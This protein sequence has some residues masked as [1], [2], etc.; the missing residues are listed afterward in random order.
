MAGIKS[1][2]KDTAIYG[3]SSMVGKFLNW[4]L[5]PFYTYTLK[6]SGEYGIVT[7]LYGW[8]ALVI[9]ILTYGMETGFF[10]FAN[11]DDRNPEQVYSTTLCSLAVTSLLFI[12]LGLVFLPDISQWMGYAEHPEF[13][14]MMICIVAVDAFCCIP[15]AYLRYKNKAKT[16]AGIK[17]LMIFVNILFNLFFLWLCPK[18]HATNPEAI[19]WFFKPD[20][21]VG[22][23]FLSN[24]FSTGITFLLL[25]PYFIHVKVDFNREL[26]G[27]M[28]R[29]SMPLLVLGIAGI[30]NQT[31]DKVIFKH[32]F[33]DQATAQEQLGIYGACYKIAII[34]M[35]F[36]QAFR[37]AYEPFIFA[38]NKSE[39]NRK[40]YSEAM[41][42]Y[43]IFALFIFL[44]VMFYIDIIKYIISSNYHSGLSVVPI[45]LACYLFQGIY[46]NLSLWYK[47]TDRTQW[48]AYI[49]LF[50]CLLTVLGN[51]MFVPEYG[52]IAAAWTSFVC[53]FLMMI[54]CWALGQKFYPIRYEM[55]SALFYLVL[56][57]VL[58]ALGMNLPFDSLWLTLGVRTVLLGVFGI[59]VLKKDIPLAYLKRS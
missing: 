16:F 21:G 49:S 15:F 55:K 35:M 36:T 29:Y 38:K 30:M 59:I 19:S 3:L 6:A 34:M 33:D 47:L 58:Y 28:L 46:F 25:L 56:T 43:I 26:W 57:M 13:V 45:I 51:I 9:V 17:L 10:R 41:K 11:K 18:I 53:Y 27:K 32:L 20:Y 40:A 44:A 31:F 14:G 42:Y 2:A 48:G 50:G 54:I 23:I 52:Y 4:C 12:I 8:T 39:D 24:V 5:V 22:Y 1:L 37:Y 7:E